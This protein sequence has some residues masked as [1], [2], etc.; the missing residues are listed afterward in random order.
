[1][2]TITDS[3]QVEEKGRERGKLSTS[4]ILLSALNVFINYKELS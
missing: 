4:S 3:N 1:M 2:W